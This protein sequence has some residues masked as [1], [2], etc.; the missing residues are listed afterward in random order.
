MAAGFVD[1]L[2]ALGYWLAGRPV[3]A[4]ARLQVE[5]HSSVVLSAEPHAVTRLA[6]EPHSEVV[7]AAELV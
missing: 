2:H 7:F 4:M 1:L 3:P 6:V 5:A